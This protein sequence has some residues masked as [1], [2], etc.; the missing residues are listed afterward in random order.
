MKHL[1]RFNEDLDDHEKLFKEELQ[2]FCDNNLVYL[3]DEGAEI[4]LNQET[5]MIR[6]DEVKSWDEIK[7]HIIPFMTRLNNKYEIDS[8]IRIYFFG[9]TSGTIELE[10]IINDNLQ[11]SSDKSQ[12]SQISI[13]VKGY[14]KEPKKSVLSKLKSFFK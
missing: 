6:F 12:I 10:S 2:D 13:Y 5:I 3:T 7:D 4:T 8:S 1:K 11:L 9:S 14:R